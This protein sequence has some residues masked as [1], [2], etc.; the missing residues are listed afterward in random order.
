MGF[1]V[2][3]MPTA[4]TQTGAHSP[5]SRSDL[6]KVRGLHPLQ[7]ICTARLHKGFKHLSASEQ[8][9]GL[10]EDCPPRVPHTRTETAPRPSWAAY[11]GLTFP[12]PVFS[13][14]RSTNKLNIRD[15]IIPVGNKGRDLPPV[16]FL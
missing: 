2:S 15:L 16:H 10:S 3:C 4:L 6:L 5:T 11:S 7:R 8:A 14:V 1:P 9:A 13:S 12:T